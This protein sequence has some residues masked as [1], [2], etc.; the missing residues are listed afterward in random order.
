V[1]EKGLDDFAPWDKA[2]EVG[3]NNDAAVV[4]VAALLCTHDVR[5][6]VAVEGTAQAERTRSEGKSGR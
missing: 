2:A 1:N 3:R 5:F 4:C 6:P